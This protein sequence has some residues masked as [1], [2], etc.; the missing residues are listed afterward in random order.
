MTL[1]RVGYEEI[2]GVDEKTSKKERL[3]IL[4]ANDVKMGQICL[5]IT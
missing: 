2:S 1:K 5:P 3:G 4:K